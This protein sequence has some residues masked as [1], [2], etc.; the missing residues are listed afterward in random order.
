MYKQK[1]WWRPVFP[2]CRIGCQHNTTQTC[3]ASCLN[4]GGLRGGRRVSSQVIDLEEVAHTQSLRSFH[5][6]AHDA[7]QD[8]RRFL[9]VQLIPLMAAE[10]RRVM[11]AG[12]VVDDV[13][14]PD[15][16]YNPLNSVY[17]PRKKQ[18]RNP[19]VA[20][21]IPCTNK[22]THQRLARIFTISPNKH[23]NN[24]KR[25]KRTRSHTLH[26]AAVTA[27]HSAPLSHHCK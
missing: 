20:P 5:T 6:H 23:T 14:P 19:L 21:P 16:S 10:A 2:V 8:R 3:I 25:K 13:L 12:L 27:R 9:T 22:R 11:D 15:K 18:T 4:N 26:L 7:T 24:L 1:N 17:A